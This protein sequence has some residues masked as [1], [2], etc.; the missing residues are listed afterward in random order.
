M[1][2]II[3]ILILTFIV[4]ACQKNSSV[5]VSGKIINPT[6]TLA[7]VHINYFESNDTI[8]VESDGTFIAEI[9]LEE[10]HLAGFYYQNNMFPLYLEPGGNIVIEFDTKDFRNGTNANI[11]LSGEKSA[12]TALLNSIDGKW[13]QFNWPEIL[14]MPVDSFLLFARS[15]QKEVNDELEILKTD[16]SPSDNFIKRA[17]LR[18]DVMLVSGIEYYEMIAGRS[19]RIP[20]GSFAEFTNKIP[21][22]DEEL[23]KEVQE[24]CSYLIPRFKREISNKMKASKL[25]KETSAYINRLADEIIALNVPQQIKDEVGRYN[26]SVFYKRPD[27]LRQVYR[28]RY[29]DVVKNQEYLDEFMKIA[30]ARD[31]IEIGR[32]APTFNY[33]DINGKMVSLE[34]FK[35]K[36]V[37]IDVWA[38]WCSPCIGEIPHLKKLEEE[39]NNE[40]IV[41]V[42]VSI[43]REKDKEAWKNMI[44]EKE[45]GG[46]QLYASGDWESKIA[47]DYVI[48]GIPYFI[49]VDKEGKLVEV[50]ASRPSKPETK[51]KL[52]KLAQS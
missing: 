41:F 36:V 7:S 31:R 11:S 1:K 46:Y 24:Y 21:K 8:S 6:D 43:D 49:I 51:Q 10:E 25:H 47:K 39:L 18:Y 12:T 40:D 22:N 3:P 14:K 19:T 26:F 37:Y 16:H 23:C 27:S 28:A 17:K 34:S 30:D 50:N 38:T 35:G 15:V 20:I 52:L 13:R 5:V 45:L 9:P 44:K 42:S 4:F 2:K 29:P 33:P 32:L 48:R